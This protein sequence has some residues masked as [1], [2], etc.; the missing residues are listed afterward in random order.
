MAQVFGL[1]VS[2]VAESD[3]E[4]TGSLR[5]EAIGALAE[6]ALLSPMMGDGNLVFGDC[7]ESEAGEDLTDGSESE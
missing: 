1:A 5:G 4:L 7:E 2:Q 3:D 6:H